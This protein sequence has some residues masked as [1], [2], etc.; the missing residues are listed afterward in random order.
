MFDDSKFHDL[1]NKEKDILLNKDFSRFLFEINGTQQSISVPLD[2]A[3]RLY[4]A[5][6]E[7]TNVE[8]VKTQ[9][10]V[11]NGL[12]HIG[13]LKK[14][15][16]N[17]LIITANNIYRLTCLLED[18]GELSKFSWIPETFKDPNIKHLEFN[19]R[20][21]YYLIW[22]TVKPNFIIPNNHQMLSVAISQFKNYPTETKG[23]FVAQDSVEYEVSR[24]VSSS[25]SNNKQ[26]LEMKEKIQ[27]SGST[28]KKTK[29][30]FE[31]KSEVSFKEPIQETPPSTPDQNLVSTDAILAL[32]ISLTD[33]EVGLKEKVKRSILQGQLF[34][35][36]HTLSLDEELDFDFTMEEVSALLNDSINTYLNSSKTKNEPV[37]ALLFV[38]DKN[39]PF[40]T[41]NVNKV[42]LLSGSLNMDDTSLSELMQA[43][44]FIRSLNIK[45]EVI[46]LLFS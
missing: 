33:S 44:G 12:E 35:K 7:N 43:V 21:I 25:L 11:K 45:K 37:S 15:G 39:K 16:K 30:T 24:Q 34:T 8:I 26:L 6:Q 40:N 18:A 4:R 28:L 20:F 5:I 32:E 13:K 17:S 27:N 36:M 22:G 3:A 42:I 10:F 23:A 9:D 29:D 38:D 41:E 46:E 19:H 1:F 14:A 2:E 31:P